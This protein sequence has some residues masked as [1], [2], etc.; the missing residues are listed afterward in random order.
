MSVALVTTFYGS[1][2]ANLFFT[3]MAIK[4][5][6]KSSQEILLKE[7]MLEGMLSIQAGENP[8]YRRKV[9]GFSTPKDRLN[10]EGNN[11]VEDE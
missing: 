2:L 7:I 1:M 11:P 9:K 6:Y 8:Y 10:R 4:L 5:K 3:P